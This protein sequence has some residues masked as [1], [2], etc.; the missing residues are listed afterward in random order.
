MADDLYTPLTRKQKTSRRLRIGAMPALAIST[1][2]L[3]GIG[4]YA[5]FINDP[6][7]GEPYKI[8]PVP[9]PLA[10]APQADT[11]NQVI[12]NK[13][14]ETAA[15]PDPSTT[16][17]PALDRVGKPTVSILTPGG[18]GGQMLVKTITLPK[19]GAGADIV[20]APDARIIEKTRVG[21]LPK[22]GG[23]GSRASKLYARPYDASAGPLP[24]NAPKIAIL[25]GGLGLSQSGT[26]ETITRLP[27][28]ITLAF[29]PYGNQLQTQVDKAREVGHEVMLQIPMEP[30]DYPSNDPG[31]QTL[32]SSLPREQNLNR[33][34]WSYSRFAGYTGIVNYL[35]AKFS[36]NTA[37][38]RPIMQ[39]ASERGLSVVDDGS[40]P[41]TVSD[42]IAQDLKLGYK[43]A[44]LTVDVVPSPDKIDEAL[45]ALEQE[46]RNNGSALGMASALP[47]TIERLSKWAKELEGRGIA[48]VPVSAVVSGEPSS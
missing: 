7:G 15:E 17:D 22:I 24:A 40:S 9:P 33:L 37:S 2:V 21:L 41:R 12:P 14:F 11:G 6:L 44:R 13:S 20:I 8:V 47:V 1:L 23:D 29:A 25:V 10:P 19:E 26:A 28:A 34:Y 39:D 3:G 36:S 16:I 32:L 5:V 30:F 4:A 31:P 42:Q 35:G 18:E 48:L 46:A 38:L 43:K 45:A 27:P